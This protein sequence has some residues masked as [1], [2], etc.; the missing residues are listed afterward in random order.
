MYNSQKTTLVN[1]KIDNGIIQNPD[2]LRAGDMILFAGIDSSRPLRI[3]HVEMVH[4][5]S[6]NGNWII[7]GHG[8][9]KPSYKDMNSYCKS[10]Y[11][12]WA[13]GGW[14]R[15]IV[16]VK[17]YIQD[18]KIDKKS[19]W[20]NEDGWKFYLGDTGECV[21]NNW[22][23][24][25]TGR[26]AWFDATGKAI[27]NNWYE[28]EG[29]WFWFGPDCYMYSSQWI[30]YKGNQYYLTSDGSMAKSTYIKSKD[31]A[32]NIYYFVNKDGIYVPE[33]DTETPNSHPIAI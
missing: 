3:G 5:R 10:R 16:C 9:N 18:D 30:T 27:S 23:S 20:Y 11:N 26:W 6:S 19:G 29:N 17:R 32:L 2:V 14:R 33:M 4:H 13:P 7:A 21:R 31:P 12:S 15:G 28:C 1:V 8:S 25:S 22:Y 24:D